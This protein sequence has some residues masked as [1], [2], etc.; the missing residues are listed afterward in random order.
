MADLIGSK[1]DYANLSNTPTADQLTLKLVLEYYD[2][3]IE[4]YIYTYTTK[5]EEK[6][7]LKCSYA[8]FPHLI[9]LHYAANA[10]YGRNHKKTEE[11]KGFEAYKGIKSGSIIKQTIKEIYPEKK[12]HYKDMTRKIRYFYNLHKVLES[13]SAVY[14]NKSNSEKKKNNAIDC[15]ILLYKIIDNQYIHVGL[16]EEGGKYVP[17]TFLVEPGPVFIDGQTVIEIE[18]SEKIRH[19]RTK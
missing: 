5:S 10:K 8:N 18:K 7:N 19:K 15:D 16:D 6:I 2:D 4:P 3:Y 12:E 1:D 13:P 11:F 14:Y 17:K 9:G